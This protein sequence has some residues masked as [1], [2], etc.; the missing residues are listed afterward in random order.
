MDV[1]LLVETNFLRN[2]RILPPNLLLESVHSGVS[3]LNC[4]YL[5]VTDL[6][7]YA[8]LWQGHEGS[9]MSY[10]LIGIDVIRETLGPVQA[11]KVKRRLNPIP[12]EPN[13]DAPI[14]ASD[15]NIHAAHKRYIES[16]DEACLI[17]I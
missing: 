12:I 2:A 10:C 9:L 15:P 1:T 7:Q 14:W 17:E 5:G 16:G 3:L 13:D 4:L 11:V 8:K 6:P